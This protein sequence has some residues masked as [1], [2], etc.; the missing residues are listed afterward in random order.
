MNR[1]ELVMG[2]S[3]MLHDGEVGIKLAT[4]RAYKPGKYHGIEKG[5][6]FNAKH[7]ENSVPSIC[8][9][10]SKG[11]SVTEYEPALLMLDGY[12]DSEVAAKSLAE[13]YPGFNRETPSALIV[14]AAEALINRIYP[15]KENTLPLWVGDISDAIRRPENAELFYPSW[16]FWFIK[17][18]GSTIDDFHEWMVANDLLVDWQKDNIVRWKKQ[19]NGEYQILSKSDRTEKLIDKFFE[20]NRRLTPSFERAILLRRSTSD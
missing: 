20:Q 2:D 13:Y 12:L 19:Y 11:H 6:A 5:L 7:Q 17:Q 1:P 15:T 14:Y 9:T 10:A 16:A 18:Y 3:G 8:L 4:I